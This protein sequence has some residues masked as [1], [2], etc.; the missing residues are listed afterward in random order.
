M[1][2]CSCNKSVSRSSET[3][4]GIVLRYADNFGHFTTM[5]AELTESGIV[6]LRAQPNRIWYMLAS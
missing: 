6:G 1:T 3:K 4:F 2:L 5:A